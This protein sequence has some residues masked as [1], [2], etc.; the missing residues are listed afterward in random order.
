MFTALYC[1]WYKRVSQQPSP[2][3]AKRYNC[4]F[5]LWKNPISCHAI[6]MRCSCPSRLLLLYSSISIDSLI[7]SIHWELHVLCQ[8]PRE[9]QTLAQEDTK[10]Q[11]RVFHRRSLLQSTATLSTGWRYKRYW[12]EILDQV[13]IYTPW[14]VALNMLH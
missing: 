2:W 3:K 13:S 10:Y 9:M 6:T 12:Y 11:W 8:V 1:Y 14:H 7:A 5:F 4:N